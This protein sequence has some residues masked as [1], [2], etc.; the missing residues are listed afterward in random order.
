MNDPS[1][2]VFGHT[3]KHLFPLLRTRGQPDPLGYASALQLENPGPSA[4]GRRPEFG[5]HLLSMPLAQTET[6]KALGQV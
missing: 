3:P 6:V 2:D 4:Q 5:P 1:V